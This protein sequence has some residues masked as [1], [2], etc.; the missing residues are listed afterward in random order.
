RA[1]LDA[2]RARP[3]PR[4]QRDVRHGAEEPAAAPARG[5]GAGAP[6][7]AGDALVQRVPDAARAS[8][9]APARLLAR[10]ARRDRRRRGPAGLPAGRWDRR[11]LAPRAGVAWRALLL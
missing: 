3:R 11:R 8:P 5:L 7:R 10:H 1:S 9:A 2:A 4:A 6:P